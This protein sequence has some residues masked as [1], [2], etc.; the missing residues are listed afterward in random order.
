[1]ARAG[2]TASKR[3]QIYESIKSDIISGKYPGGTFLL[4][5][6]LCE[7]FHVSRTP[8]REALI[9]LA[10][11]H[12]IE[13]YPKRGAFVPQVT[14]K[15]ILE[16]YELR[17]ANDGVAAFLFT[18]N[19]A[20]EV[21]RQME[22]SVL[23]EEAHLEHENYAGEV[24]EELLFHS[25]YI[26]NCGNQRMIDVIEMVNSQMLRIMTL[27]ADK[28][29]MEHMYASLNYHKKLIEAVREHDPHRA[30]AIV[31]GHWLTAKRGLKQRYIEGTLSNRL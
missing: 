25:L 22:A 11:D 1:M 12:I 13:M 28:N 23:R 21:V 4:E 31:E 16:L 2:S 14:V 5:S 17:I 18:E 26:S 8:I 20:E 7:D 24:E 10:H 30:R 19:A 27:A 3:D 6:E 29:D 15:D 9:R